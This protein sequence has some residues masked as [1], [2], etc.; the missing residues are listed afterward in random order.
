MKKVLSLL[1]FSAVMFA[2]CQEDWEVQQE[3]TGEESVVR[4]TLQAPEAMGVTRAGAGY[5]NSAKGGITNVD[6][7][8]YDLRYQVA[9]YDKDGVTQIV[10]PKIVTV[11]DASASTQASFEVRLVN[12][13]TY[14]FVAWADFVAE[15]TTDDKHYDT[16]DLTNITCKD[17][18][19]AQ[20]NDESRDAYFVTTNE[21]VSTDGVKLTLRRPFA[22][23]RIVTTDWN[24]NDPE[25][26]PNKI[27]IAYYGC[28]RFAGINAVTGDALGGEE[29]LP[30]WTDEG[31]THYTVAIDPD[32]KDYSGG[33]DAGEDGILDGAQGVDGEEDGEDAST[34][35]TAT[36]EED[37]G[38][39]EDYENR[40]LMVDYLVASPKQTTIKLWFQAFDDNQKISGYRFST[41]IPIQRNYLTTLLGNLLTENIK[42]TMTCDENFEEEFNAP[43]IEIVTG[44]EPNREGNTYFIESV[45]NLV[46]LSEQ[47]QAKNGLVNANFPEVKGGYTFKLV[48]DIDMEGIDWT[49]IYWWP[50]N[51][52]GNSAGT[53]DGDGHTIRN[54]TIDAERKAQQGL[55]GQAVI[56]I[57]NLTV[58]NATINN[59]GNFTG[60]IAGNL[61]GDLENCKVSHIFIR[62]YDYT[63]ANPPTVIRVGG[64]VG[65]HNNG[66]MKNCTAEDVNVKGYHSVGG[67]TGFVNET[68]NR[69]YESCRV[70]DS[71]LWNTA[72][73]G[74][75]GKQIGAI[76]GVAGVS[77]TLKDCSSANMEYKIG[78][79]NEENGTPYIM[80][81][82]EEGSKEYGPQHALY[83]NP[84][85]I[86]VE[87]SDSNS[88]P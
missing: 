14:K 61:Y 42:V 57:K 51:S 34:A 27:D 4:I 29:N 32:V 43:G 63:T 52:D 60:A 56:G 74:A 17:A 64:M 66:F 38:V 5:T 16:S 55:F 65:I 12:N 62:S 79:Y 69:K 19:A 87:D 31:I 82:G 77:L 75:G 1:A 15:G 44:V 25:R 39:A 76:V 80:V 41:D 46:W 70:T 86:T 13:R 35:S 71:H 40:T 23:V 88:E 7:T 20:L 45:A 53:F 22:K 2:G 48:N 83:G 9:V 18:V 67:L 68:P 85:N 3:G 30:S 33:Y 11:P 36:E 28:K 26:R 10:S 8:K 54:L 73:S 84:N 47:S 78:P 81:S 58:E 24:A 72:S 49:P 59:A 50:T 37:T 21:K 6:W